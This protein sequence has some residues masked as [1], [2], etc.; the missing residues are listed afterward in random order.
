MRLFVV[1][2]IHGCFDLLEVELAK[3]GF[4]KAQDTLVS[5]GDLV[6]RG[7]QSALAISYLEKS[8]FKAIMGNH[9]AMCHPS[10]GGSPWHCMNG[11]DW[12]NELPEPQKFVKP[13]LELPVTL[14]VE[15][16]GKAY[17]FVHASVCGNRDWNRIEEIAEGFNKF[18]EHPFLWDRTDFYGAKQLMQG[19]AKGWDE[20]HFTI[21]NIEHVYFGHTPIKEPM[22]VGNCTW[23]DTGAF[24]TDNLT[25]IEIA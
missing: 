9:E 11:G 20:S 17:G 1:G 3:V 19:A 23:L 13:L 2:D 4:N 12:Y 10:Y 7:P 22:T 18:D 5:V 14:K 8:W 16:N 24:A 6:D 25:V 15:H 21:E